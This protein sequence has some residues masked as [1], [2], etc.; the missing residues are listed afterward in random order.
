MIEKNK[1]CFVIMGF[2]KKMDYMQGK[3]I[4]LDLLYNKV[5]QYVFQ[6]R[7]PEYTLIRSDEISI[8]QM[9]DASMYALIMKADLVIAVISTLNANAL[10]EL[11]IRHSEKPF[12]TI[13][14]MQE[15]EKR[16]IPFD[17]NHIRILTY[18]DYDE[19]LSE[20]EAAAI[21]GQLRECIANVEIEAIDSPIFA[22]L[23]EEGRPDNIDRQFQ[24]VLKSFQNKKRDKSVRMMIDEAKSYQKKDNLEEA[25][26]IWKTLH[27]VIP[28]DPYIIQQMAF[29]QYKS[30]E[31]KSERPGP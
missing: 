19:E 9:I 8:S 29:S 31:K 27:N 18:Q 2:G 13:I 23:P 11:G 24:I 20:K 1:T 4:D 14:M 3:E 17:L 6:E 25:E 26:K 28:K 16:M 10:Y 22:T 30:G 15:S 5:I 7:F 21:R 12:S